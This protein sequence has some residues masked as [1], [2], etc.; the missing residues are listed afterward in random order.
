MSFAKGL[1]R[2]GIASSSQTSGSSSLVCI[3]DDCWKDSRHSVQKAKTHARLGK[4]RVRVPCKVI[5]LTNPFSILGE[6]QGEGNEDMDE[7]LAK[8]F[9][10][11]SP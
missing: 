7:G 9:V 11:L 3:N 6:V 1:A 5:Y 8:E 2:E 10:P 4:P